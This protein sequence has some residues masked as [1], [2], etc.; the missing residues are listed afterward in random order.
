MLGCHGH[1]NDLYRHVGVKLPLKCEKRRKLQANFYSTPTLRQ[2]EG[3]LVEQ[4]KLS[5]YSEWRKANPRECSVEEV[6]RRHCFKKEGLV[7]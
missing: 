1:M 4:R 6:K 7:K 5:R 3:K 2:Q